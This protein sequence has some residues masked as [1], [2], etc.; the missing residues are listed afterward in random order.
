MR[1]EESGICD[2]VFEGSAGV[3]IVSENSLAESGIRNIFLS[4]HNCMCVFISRSVYVRH[5][6]LRRNEQD[7]E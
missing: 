1:S 6:V 5:L 2:G 4:L 3:H 7:L